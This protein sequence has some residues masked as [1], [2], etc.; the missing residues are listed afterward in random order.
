MGKLDVKYSAKL[1]KP[2]PLWAA[3]PCVMTKHSKFPTEG[4]GSEE[5]TPKGEAV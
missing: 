4:A 1:L 2:I 3:K 5:L